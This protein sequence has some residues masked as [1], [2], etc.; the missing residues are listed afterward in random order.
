VE[1]REGEEKGREGETE[2]DY[3]ER[4]IMKVPPIILKYLLSL[5]F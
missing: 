3:S 4:N 2:R 5:V 1:K